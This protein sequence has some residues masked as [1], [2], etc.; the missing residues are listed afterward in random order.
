MHAVKSFSWILKKKF[1]EVVNRFSNEM[2]SMLHYEFHT[3]MTSSTV[4]F[5]NVTNFVFS[6]NAFHS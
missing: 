1:E 3:K 4:Y 6:C 2:D 5:K